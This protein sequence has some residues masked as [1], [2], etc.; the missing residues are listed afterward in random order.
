MV[1]CIYC[2]TIF[3]KKGECPGCKQEPYLLIES[4]ILRI[5]NA[6]DHINNLLD[7]LHEEE[8][9]EAITELKE[10]FEELLQLQYTLER[11]CGNVRGN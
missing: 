6:D 4:A 10:V 8:Y 7:C 2:G 11:M 9:F 3:D 1:V 5:E